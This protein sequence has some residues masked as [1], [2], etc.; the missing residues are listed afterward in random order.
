MKSLSIIM[1]L[2]G[3]LVLGVLPVRGHD[4]RH[5]DGELSRHDMCLTYSSSDHIVDVIVYP[6]TIRGDGS[7]DTHIRLKLKRS[8]GG[9]LEEWEVEVPVKDT[10]MVTKIRHDSIRFFSKEGKYRLE[11]DYEDKSGDGKLREAVYRF[12]GKKYVGVKMSEKK[13]K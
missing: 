2:A 11:F 8:T 6:H 12:S 7:Y 13:V 10:E 1:L 9:K 5:V 4:V 3:F